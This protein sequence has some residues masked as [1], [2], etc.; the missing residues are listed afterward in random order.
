MDVRALAAKIAAK[1]NTRNPLQIAEDLGFI[2]VF[3]PLVDMRGYHQRIRRRNI[4]YINSDLDEQQQRLVCAHELGHYFMHRGMNRIFMDHS[5]Q[6]V[7][8]KFENEAHCFSMELIYSDEELSLFL[9][10]PIS[11]AAAY[12]GVSLQMAERRMSTVEPSI[13]GM[14]E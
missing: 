14:Y 11:D 7:T 8:Q 4:I 1:H 10:R 13:W 2:I 12:M 5:T 9:S 6:I 3:A